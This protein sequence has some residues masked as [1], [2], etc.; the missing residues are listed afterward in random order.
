MGIVDRLF[1]ETIEALKQGKIILAIVLLVTVAAL[2]G[3]IFCL[4]GCWKEKTKLKDYIK[5]SVLVKVFGGL[6]LIGLVASFICFATNQNEKT[7]LV[8]NQLVQSYEDEKEGLDQTILPA[9]S[10]SCGE[11]SLSTQHEGFY[12]LGRNDTIEIYADCSQNQLAVNWSCD[13]GF[14]ET[15][16][17]STNTLGMAVLGYYIEPV[18]IGKKMQSDAY[19][20]R[21][22]DFEDPTHGVIALSDCAPGYYCL[23]VQ[24]IGTLE[25][26]TDESTGIRY[27]SS[28][29]WM[30]YWIQIR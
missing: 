22:I 18:T 24:A 17:Q 15:L 30:K 12:V 2:I 16:G 5:K 10:V 9:V 7:K 27:H 4:R 29:S 23:G 11:E 1:G 19:Q 20:S 28:T 25:N 3:L 6:F 26:W 8:E 14:M 13:A 21:I